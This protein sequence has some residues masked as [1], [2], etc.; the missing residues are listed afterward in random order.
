[1]EKVCTLCKKE[2]KKEDAITM[3]YGKDVN[4]N[5]PTYFSLPKLHIC[6]KCF[7]KVFKD[8]FSFLI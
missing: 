5:A 7:K 8:K 2:L 4:P 6:E 3:I 1:L